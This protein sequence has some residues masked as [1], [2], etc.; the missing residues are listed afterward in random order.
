MADPGMLSQILGLVDQ[1]M[2]PQEAKSAL[3]Q[4]RL[5]EMAKM[6]PAQQSY[7]G[8]AESGSRMA[9]GLGRL[10]GGGQEEDAMLRKAS[11]F[12]S[13]RNQI[14]PTSSSSLAAASK[15]M[16]SLGFKAQGDMYAKMALEAEKQKSEINLKGAQT[17]K[18]SAESQEIFDKRA[19]KNSRVQMLKEAGFS[20]NEANGIASNDAAFAKQ[21]E[22]KN[23][24]TPADY[25]VQAVKL[26]F[27]SKS[28]LS[29]YTPEQMNAMEKA[30]FAH[31]AGVAQ[32]GAAINKP[33]DVAAIIKEIGTTQDI[34]DK[35][36]VWKTA[37]DAYKMQVPMVEKLKEVRNNLPTTF[38]GAFSDTALQF[39]KGLSALGV[40]VDENKL[41]NTEYMN[42]VS[43]QVLQTIARNF[44]G[45]L[46]VKEMEQLVKSKF[47]SQQQIKTISRILG[48]LQTEI[49][50]GTKSYEQLAKLP[51]TERY[52]KDLN[53]LT[54]QN[55]NK[56]KKYRA[57][58]DKARDAL[59]TGKPMPKAEVDEARQLQKELGE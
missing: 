4:A 23:I 43:S 5:M 54:G 30:V 48:D 27:G 13:M 31:K 45:S 55:F 51:E 50:A 1:G 42:S 34:K 44:P 20:D 19:A 7:Y 53:L 28:K 37:G 18:T 25:A 26:G 35:A 32:A 6:T 58:E 46:A 40:P 36:N 56:I 49:E 47:N 16:Y 52:T 39:G 12:A 41:S 24:P 33:V 11:D 57:L 17:L 3:E 22:N 59:K 21:V 9:S 15:Q 2:S 10:L 38:T 8:V 29:D 14:D